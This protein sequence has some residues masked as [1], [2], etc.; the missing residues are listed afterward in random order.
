MN[1]ENFENFKN[2]LVEKT[3][4]ILNF[5]DENIGNEVINNKLQDLNIESLFYFK[6]F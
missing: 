2:N 4:T 6:K 1:Q 5:F 3:S